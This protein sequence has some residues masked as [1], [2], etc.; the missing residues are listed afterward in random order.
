MDVVGAVALAVGVLATIA[1]LRVR[2]QRLQHRDVVMLDGHA[3]V[4]VAVTCRLNEPDE[5]AFE[6]LGEQLARNIRIASR[7]MTLGELLVEQGW[8]PPIEGGPR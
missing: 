6:P 1:A 3:H 2:A 8:R 7:D 4:V 5:Y